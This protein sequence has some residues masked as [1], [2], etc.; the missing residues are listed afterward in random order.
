MKLPWTTRA[1]IS[2]IHE[3]NPQE[4]LNCMYKRYVIRS[5]LFLVILIASAF[6]SPAAVHA[7]AACESELAA[8]GE[9][10]TFGRF[11]E[12]IDLLRRCVRKRD[13]S[14]MEKQRAYRLLALSYIGK[15]DEGRA[16]E[17]VRELLLI[18]PNYQTDPDQDPPPFVD[19]I[20]EVKREMDRAQPPADA[21]DDGDKK[22]GG[23]RLLLIGGGVALAGVA[24]AVLLSGGGGD[25][26]DGDGNGGPPQPTTLDEREPNNSTAQA[27]VLRGNPPITVNGNVEVSDV[28]G[29]EVDLSGF[30]I[31]DVDDLED[32]YR[33]TL[34]EQGLRLTLSGLAADCDLYLLNPQAS[35]FINSSTG[36]GTGTETINDPNLAPGTYLIGVTIFDLEPLAQSTSYTLVV[37]GAV[38][39]ASL[40]VAQAEIQKIGGASLAENVRLVTLDGAAGVPVETVMP[41]S[42][43]SWTAY[44]SGEEGLVENDGTEAFHFRPGRGFW[45]QS[46]QAFAVPP[47][48]A[49]DPVAPGETYA[50]PLEKGWNIIANPFRTEVDWAAVQAA[51]GIT[52]NLWR[53]DGHFVPSSDFA[54]AQK[55]EAFYFMNA[56][57][58]DHLKIPHPSTR[59]TIPAGPSTTAL[60]VS[61]YREGRLASAVR[62]GFAHEAAQGFDRFDQVAPPGYFEAAGLRLMR[63][64]SSEQTLALADEFKPW[65]EEGQAFDLILAAPVHAPVELRVDGLAAFA[66]YEVVLV[67][68]EKSVVYD[69]QARSSITV[70]P[71]QG[72]SR[73]RLVVG[74]G[75]YTQAV[76]DEFA[77]EALS[78]SNYPNPF[79]PTTEITYTLPASAAREPARLEIFD[80]AGRLV[81]VLVDGLQEPGTHRVMWDGAD[82]AGI[83]V[84]SGVYLSRLHA[85]R[86]VQVN[87]MLLMK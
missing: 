28:G 18:N 53:W 77:P 43:T 30:G 12:A 57:G 85:G 3:T 16:R 5:P 10:Y 71:G 20:R 75:A 76:R 7:Q 45:I 59:F 24:A 13:A 44:H 15:D 48:E 64:L 29:V 68:L 17:N 21:G 8:A 31:D 72:Q 61:V 82:A 78:I 86:H 63:R 55:G 49:A 54:S 84:A 60:T 4:D 6:V 32:L 83:P 81:R 50:L 35:L 79:N 62:A 67:D 46:D 42:V 38:S 26:G 40:R 58:L 66:G 22:G 37:D 74:S 9:A 11:D 51:N 87:R 52:Q 70:T 27:Q 36:E 56:A 2:N 23:N 1:S 33:I 39:G 80:V 41:P 65:P 47:A 25:D 14:S 34:T 19:M 73:F 69:M